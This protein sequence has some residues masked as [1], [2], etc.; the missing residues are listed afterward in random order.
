MQNE[1]S[2]EVGG[3]ME[4]LLEKAGRELWKKVEVENG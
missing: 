3:R 1:Q 2:L 4:K